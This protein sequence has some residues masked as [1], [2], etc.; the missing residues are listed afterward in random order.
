MF[1]ARHIPGNIRNPNSENPFSSLLA[2]LRKILE[3]PATSEKIR[4]IRNPKSFSAAHPKN[5]NPKSEILFSSASHPPRRRR[6]PSPAD[7]PMTC[8][9]SRALSQTQIASPSFAGDL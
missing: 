4:K 5:P 3:S 2:V 7:G 6:L 9:A 1:R 8:S